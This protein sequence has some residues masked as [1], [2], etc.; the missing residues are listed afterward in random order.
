[1]VTEQEKAFLIERH[2]TQN[3]VEILRNTP[4]KSFEEWYKD[5]ITPGLNTIFGQNFIDQKDKNLSAS[6]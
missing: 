3:K 5:K 4:N 1:M 6:L 2:L